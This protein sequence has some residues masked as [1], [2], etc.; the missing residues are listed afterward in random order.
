[1]DTQNLTL[2]FEDADPID[3]VETLATHNAW[4]FDR[5]DD[6]QIA[7]TIEGQWQVYSLSLAWSP[8]DETLRLICT[9]DLA[10]PDGTRPKL[11]D[12]MD[13]A[14]ERLW[15]G[16]FT[17]WAAQDMIVFRY[18]LNLAGDAHASGWQIDD[19]IANAVDACERYYPAFQLACRADTPR[20]E[21][22][23]IAI[24]GAYGRA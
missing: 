18:G 12:V 3:M 10:P 8:Y 11:L 5:V 6:N 19:M 16:S 13:G 1:M 7:M 2:D 14:N 15:C 23:G 17:T 9:F 20:D 24:S 4:D 21:A 22:L